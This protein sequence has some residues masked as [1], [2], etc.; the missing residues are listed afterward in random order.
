VLT[1][2]HDGRHHRDRKARAKRTTDFGLVF[3]YSK[4]KTP[5]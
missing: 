2:I 4:G 5:D 1:V 3:L